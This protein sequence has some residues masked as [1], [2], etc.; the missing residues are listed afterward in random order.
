MVKP[1]DPFMPQPFR[2]SDGSPLS[3]V[4]RDHSPFV[5]VTNLEEQ[6]RS[7]GIPDDMRSGRLAPIFDPVRT[8]PPFE[9]TTPVGHFPKR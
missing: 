8:A 1:N 5:T 7:E 2:P 6:R 9:S 3:D 4:Q